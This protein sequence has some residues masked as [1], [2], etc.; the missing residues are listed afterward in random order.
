MLILFKLKIIFLCVYPWLQLDVCA[1]MTNYRNIM[2]EIFVTNGYDKRIQ[3]ANLGETFYV[4][5]NLYFD[6]VLQISEVDQK[7][8]SVGYFEVEWKD[9]GL[10]WVYSTHGDIEKIY[11]PQN[12]IWKPDLML[13]N[14]FTTIKEMGEAHNFVAVY[15]DGEVNWE[16][17]QV[18]ESR[19]SIDITF[20]PFDKQTC[21]L[22]FEISSFKATEVQ[23]KSSYGID[24]GDYFQEHSSWKVL[25]IRSEIDNEN[26]Y[27]SR[28]SFKIVIQRKP[29]YYV[30]NILLPVILLGSLNIFVFAIPAESGEKISYSITLLLDMSVFL[31]IVSTI[32]PR[33]SDDVSILA[34]YLLFNVFL[35]VLAVILATWLVKHHNRMD[36]VPVSGLLGRVI[37]CC[38]TNKIIKLKPYMNKNETPV[39]E[40]TALNESDN[41]CTKTTWK[42]AAKFLD[43]IFF[44]TFSVVFILS[45][46]A[47]VGTLIIYHSSPSIE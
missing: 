9:P 38:K 11:I 32:L 40:D 45:T 28:I 16:P 23:I 41:Q 35:G 27:E 25:N 29:M 5:V 37:I 7:M 24:Y 34:I 19:C 3:P 1:N 36:D 47:F 14:G 30:I 8:T 12:D 21:Q 10:T 6:G 46:F 44:W 22:D 18:F 13:Q 42:D 2:K 31:S 33:N 17:T 4:D 43:V 26:Y 15:D 39:D 20:F